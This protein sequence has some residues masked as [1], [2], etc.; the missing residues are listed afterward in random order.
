MRR[1]DTVRLTATTIRT[2]KLARGTVDKTHWDSELPGFG[3]RLRAGGSH[4]WV[5]QYAISKITRR[6]TL[7]PVS[8]LDPGKARELAKTVIA[9]KRLG[10]DPAREKLAARDQA[11]N[12]IGALLPRF[13]ERQQLKLKPRTFVETTRHLGRNIAK[14]HSWPVTTPD[15]RRLI[16]ARLSELASTNGPGEANRCRANLSA[17]FT[18][19]AREGYIESNPVTFTNKAIEKGPRQRLL[20]DSELVVIWRALDASHYADIIRLLILTGPAAKRSAD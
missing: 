8:A 20:T 3:L 15:L 1:T 4:V 14:L 19:L 9:Q 17:F 10:R 5:V 12:T 18:W 7:G 11:A 16:A 6:M 2:L 13:L